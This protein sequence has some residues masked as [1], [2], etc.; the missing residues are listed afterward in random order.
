MRPVTQADCHDLPR[1]GGELVPSRTIMIDEIVIGFEDA[2]GE[3]IIAKELPYVLPRIEFGTFRRQSDDGDVWGDDEVRR[4]MSASLIDEEHR[5]GA[6]RDAPGELGEM[7]VHRVGVAGRQDQSC[8]FPILRADSA[9]NVDRGGALT[10]G[11]ACVPRLAQRRVI[12]F[13]WPMRLIG[14]PDFYFGAIY[15][16][17]PRNFFQAR[18]EAFLKSSMVPSA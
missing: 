15:A 1:L 2:V 4:D 9:E 17:L 10:L 13:F 3:P 12:L 18:G 5:M 11:S 14:E 7:Q 8:R 6:R 16:P